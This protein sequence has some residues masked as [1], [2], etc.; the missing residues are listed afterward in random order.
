MRAKSMQNLLDHGAAWRGRGLKVRQP[1]R[2]W[3][4]PPH[5]IRLGKRHSRQMSA[6][7]EA[8][9]SRRLHFSQR[10]Y[11]DPTRLRKDSKDS[12][13]IPRD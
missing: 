3:A 12:R 7:P 4:G 11:K 6:R 8:K 2:L 9:T 5:E 10:L 1:L 13:K